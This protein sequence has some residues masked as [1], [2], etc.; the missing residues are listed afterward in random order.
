MNNSI[1]KLEFLPKKLLHGGDY[2]PEQWLD[3][4]HVLD[5]DIKLMKEANFNC[6]T[7][8]VFAWSFYE[9][10]EGKYN[11]AWLNAIIDKLYTN[12]IY[13]IL[14]TPT[15]A[16]PQWLT[17]KYEEVLQVDE[18]GMRN[19]PG[20]RH[21]FCP[22]SQILKSKMKQLNSKLSKYLGNH[23]G[24]IA[25]HISN[26]YGGNG[27]DASCHCTLCQE[28]FRKWLKVKYTT[29]EL[30][31][32]AWWTSFWSHTF[33]DWTQIQSPS[34]RGEKLIHGL[35]LDWKRFTSYQLLEFCKSEIQTVR[36]FSFLPVTT[37]MMGYFK[38]LN[39]FE[40]AKEVDIISWD[41]YPNWHSEEDEIRIAIETAFSH[42][43]MRSLKKAP[44]LLMESTP[45]LVNY[46]PKN[47]LKRP[48]MHALSSL[49]AIAYGSNSVQ[50]FQWRKSRGSCEKYHGAVVDHKNGS[51]T[52]V[53]RDV[54]ELG[55][56]LE[57]ISDSV[58]KTCN[59]SKVALLFDW[60]N[61]WA[62]E[63]AFAVEYP[64]NYTFLFLSYYQ[65]LWEMGI[66]VDIIDMGSEISGYK[67]VIAPL[68][69]LYTDGYSKK[70]SQY[71]DAG[72]I[73]VTTYWSGEVNETDL[74]FI[75][76]HPLQD[77]LGIWVEEI[78]TPGD[79][80]HN[81]IN[82]YGSLFDVTG[83]CGLIH[84][85]SAEVLATYCE[86][87]Y[88]GYP[89]LTKNSYGKGAAYFIAS[90]NE[91]AFIKDLY[92][93]I[94]KQSQITCDFK[95]SFPFP[96]GVTV[97]RRVGEGDYVVWF[98]QNFNREEILINLYGTYIDL[99]S[100]KVFKEKIQIGA[101][102]CLILRELEN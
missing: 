41:S 34:C 52:R 75:N 43:L 53:F 14:A 26:E 20:N 98:L 32:H 78:D 96:E 10:E 59:Q 33:S 21:N 66:D 64:I 49:Q 38:P 5:E 90:Q 19:F 3:Y 87:F 7:L 29:L 93:S 69:Y 44:F 6:V 15:G 76:K 51:N 2:N 47:I 30:L 17:A 80:Y 22:S 62:V 84:T 46:K 13:T 83:L 12:N 16:L 48:G 1:N 4:P 39:Y 8:G 71:V 31:N 70:I 65:P 82:Y 60:E 61:W 25:W 9:P 79:L 18:Y 50:Y 36:E 58:Y 100:G 42:N 91:N 92:I 56:Y 24:I 81:Q 40:W 55:K 94:L 37:N 101:L 86:D 77:V 67:V 85:V 74:C 23:P 88:A 54:S 28:A 72:G 45:S 97:S 27:K 63:D 89:A 73:Y 102:T 99:Y 95:A 68:N 35:N 57:M 11:F